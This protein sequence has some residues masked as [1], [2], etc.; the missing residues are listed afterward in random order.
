MIA[1]LKNES[2]AEVVEEILTNPNYEC[3]AHAVNYSELYT[4]FLKKGSLA[5][6]E[7][8]VADMI[9]AGIKLHGDI[10]EQFWK[11]VGRLKAAIT[12]TYII[13]TLSLRSIALADCFAVAL[14]KRLCGDVVTSDHHELEY[15]HNS[16]ECPIHF[17][18]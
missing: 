17:F 4:W 13:P 9:N 14:G 3:V 2:G 10:D 18:R 12:S 16:G 5:D 1:F 8:A 7:G 11:E 15:V 6:A